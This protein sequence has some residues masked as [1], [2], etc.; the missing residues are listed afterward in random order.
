LPPKLQ[1]FSQVCGF[2]F[3]NQAEN[4]SFRRFLR[5]LAFS[6]VVAIVAVGGFLL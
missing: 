2:T 1:I 3:L 4:L 5:G 6:L